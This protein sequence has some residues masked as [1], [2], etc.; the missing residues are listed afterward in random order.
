MCCQKTIGLMC[1]IVWALA[2]SLS[3]RSVNSLGIP[4][5]SSWQDMVASLEVERGIKDCL[6]YFFIR[7]FFCY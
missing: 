2:H 4:S 6:L 1:G 3:D 7:L 5:H